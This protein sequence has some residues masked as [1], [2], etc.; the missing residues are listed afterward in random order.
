[1]TV[2]RYDISDSDI[3]CPHCDSTNTEAHTLPG[4]FVRR[5]DIVCGDCG[6]RTFQ[7]GG[8]APGQVDDR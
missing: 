4:F 3:P 5:I 6:K 2:Q 7:G 8:L 1:M